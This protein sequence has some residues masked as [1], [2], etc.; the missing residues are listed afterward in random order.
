MDD[1]QAKE[2]MTSS[3]GVHLVLDSSFLPGDSGIMVPHTDDGRVLFAVPWHNMTLIGTTE[4][5]VTKFPLEPIPMESEITFL[6]EHAA[7]Y[8]TKDPKRSDVKSVFA[9][10]RPL[11][12]NGDNEDDTASI[13]RDH[14]ITIS[15]SGLISIAGGKWTTYR[16]MAEDVVEQAI[17]LGNLPSSDSV[18]STLQIHGYHKNS[19]NYGH[20]NN[21]GSDAIKIEELLN[22][23]TEFNKRLH[24]DHEIRIGEI[25]WAV[26]NEMA[27]NIED[28]LAR[29]SQLL[30]LDAKA[31][32]EV[33]P[34]VAKIMGKELGQSWR[35]RKN[36]IQQFSELA[37][38]YL[39]Y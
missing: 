7:K 11:V 23:N 21:Y 17:I 13:S 10:L 24:P 27:R 31:S 18:T 25:I 38:N 15:K 16:K 9:G 3:Q 35:W 28:F 36:Q 26:R 14:T 1:N 32:I 5:L 19:H 34:I 2:I 29:R 30:I 12:K 6:L 37:K 22:A 8:L 33:A 4:T 39:L 20:L